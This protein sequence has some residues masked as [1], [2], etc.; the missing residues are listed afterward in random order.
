MTG[1]SGEPSRTLMAV[2]L[3]GNDSADSDKREEGWKREIILN[4]KQS[5]L[6]RIPEEVKDRFGRRK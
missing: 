3:M 5:E 6:H 4:L 1:E 2:N